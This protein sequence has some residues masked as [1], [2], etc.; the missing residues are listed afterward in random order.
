MLFFSPKVRKTESPEVVF[1][2]LIDLLFMLISFGLPDYFSIFLTL[3]Y[4]RVI[5]S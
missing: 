2:L 3:M 4:L 5:F 1:S